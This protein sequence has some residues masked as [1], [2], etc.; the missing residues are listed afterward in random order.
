MKPDLEKAIRGLEICIEN[1][2]KAECP[3]ECPYYE[4]CVA[5]DRRCIFQPLMRDALSLIRQQA[6]I[7][8]LQTKVHELQTA[9]TAKW[10]TLEYVRECLH[11]GDVAWLEHYDKSQVIPGIR[12]RLIN[13]GGDEAIEFHVMDGFIAA[14]LAYYG[15][16]WRCWTQ[17]PTDEQREE[18]KWKD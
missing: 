7:H 17:R 10:M 5:Y 8:E 9:Q 12:F 18:A 16:E 13:E 11:D 14:R 15:K 2:D 3:A 6:K 4:K 1:I